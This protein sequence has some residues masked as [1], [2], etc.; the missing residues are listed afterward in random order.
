MIAFYQL[1]YG[2]AAFGAGPLVDSGAELSTVYAIAASSPRPWVSCRSS[3]R[4]RAT[5]R[6]VPPEA[7]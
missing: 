5:G 2:I 6:P 3:S 7:A 4:P 1:G